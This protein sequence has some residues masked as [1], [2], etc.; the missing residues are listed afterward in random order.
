[1][2]IV[3]NFYLIAFIF[4]VKRSL[5]WPYVNNEDTR[6]L[7]LYIVN[8]NKQ[9]SCVTGVSKSMLTNSS[10]I[11]DIDTTVNNNKSSRLCVRC[12]LFDNAIDINKSK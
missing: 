1:M 8:D 6:I 4:Q 7:E 2:Y 5:L 3:S 11:S 9:V 12:K 10:V